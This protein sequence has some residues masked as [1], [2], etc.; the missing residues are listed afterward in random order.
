MASRVFPAAFESDCAACDDRIY[1]GDDI[2]MTNGEAVHEDC[3]DP[4]E[5]DE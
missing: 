2:R 1:E 4:S 5:D 3:Y